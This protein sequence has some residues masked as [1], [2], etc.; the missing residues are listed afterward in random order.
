MSVEINKSGL[1]TIKK[2]IEELFSV[3][4]MYDISNDAVN[5]YIDSF[6]NQGFTDITLIPWE[7][8]N[9]ELGATLVLSGQLRNSIRTLSVDSDSFTVISDMEYSHAHNEGEIIKISP[10]MR[11]YFWAMYNKTKKEEWKWLAL[12]KNS[13]ITIPKRQFMGESQTL[14]EMIENYTIENYFK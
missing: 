2:D 6:N 4:T 5:F 11:N 13:T 1:E 3:D 9:K 12:T 14:N 10:K 8:G 7:K